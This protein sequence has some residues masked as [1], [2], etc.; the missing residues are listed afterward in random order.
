M[1]EHSATYLDQPRRSYAE[2]VMTRQP[3]LWMIVYRDR[4]DANQRVE[5]FPTCRQAMDDI[6]DYDGN[7]W[8]YEYT[9]SV[10]GGKPEVEVWDLTAIARERRQEMPHISSRA[11]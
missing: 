11:L 6:F 5:S 3:A 9:I 10:I 8:A 7:E 1:T 4:K 2:V